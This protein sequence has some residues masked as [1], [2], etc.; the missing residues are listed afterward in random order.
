LVEKRG[1]KVKKFNRFPSFLTSF[2]FLTVF[3][4]LSTTSFWVQFEG[5]CVQ[6]TYTNSSLLAR[7]HLPVVLQMYANVRKFNW[8][9]RSISTGNSQLST[10]ISSKSTVS[11]QEHISRLS[12]TCLSL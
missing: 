11:H 4:L 9:F 3:R 1:K 8:F 10:A 7:I 5:I 6:S 12:T 2:A